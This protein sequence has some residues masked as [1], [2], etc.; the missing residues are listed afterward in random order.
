[1][2][3]TKGSERCTPVGSVRYRISNDGDKTGKPQGIPLGIALVDDLRDFNEIPLGIPWGIP[4]AIPSGISLEG[5]SG[6]VGEGVDLGPPHTHRNSQ[7]LPE[8]LSM[9]IHARTLERC[10]VR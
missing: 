10:F 8:G 1:M 7:A 6:P 3:V 4:Y 2:R 5:E 9:G